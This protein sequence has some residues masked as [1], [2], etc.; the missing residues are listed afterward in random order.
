MATGGPVT[1]RGRSLVHSRHGR[2]ITRGHFECFTGYLIETLHDRSA[3]QADA[4]EVIERINKS[5]N[6]TNGTSY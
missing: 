4:D 5:A 2:G 1:Y 6:E 3:S